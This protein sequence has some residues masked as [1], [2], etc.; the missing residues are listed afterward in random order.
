MIQNQYGNIKECPRCG[1]DSIDITDEI[2]FFGM[3]VDDFNGETVYK[4]VFCLDCKIHGP[5]EASTA[6]AIQGW[7]KRADPAQ[8]LKSVTRKVTIVTTA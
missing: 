8:K 2:D 1:G 7:N 5:F 3:T 6:R 4:S